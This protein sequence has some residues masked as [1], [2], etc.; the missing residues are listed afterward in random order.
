MKYL[1][2]LLA[3]FTLV[4]AI[5]IKSLPI[6]FGEQRVALTKEYIKDH[7]SKV[8]ENIE[9]TPCLIV[10][11]H[12]AVNDFNRSLNRFIDETLPL[13][14]GDI[15][16]ASNLNVSA[17]FLV[18]KNGD[19]YSLMGETTM[20]RH[21]IGLNFS[22]IGIENVGGQDDVDNLTD[23]QLKANVI[24]VKYLLK[25]YPT[26]KKVIAHSEYRTLENDP[27]WLEIDPAYR[28]RKT[29]PSKRFMREFRELMND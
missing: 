24:L 20:A 21:V 29:D 7:Y 13:D 28:T 22:A 1:L 16:K 23:E 17:H 3:S 18:N 9:I 15:A 2:I 10:L 6:V 27:L 11:H 25:K 8:V 19:I 26:I 4:S 5:E 14:R 12:T